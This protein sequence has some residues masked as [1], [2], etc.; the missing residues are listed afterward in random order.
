M[1]AVDRLAADILRVVA[2][3]REHIIAAALPAAPTPQYQERRW[4]LLCAVGAV[5][6]EVDPGAGAVLVAGR[7]DRFGVGEAAHIIGEN[8]GLHA[9]RTP[10]QPTHAAQD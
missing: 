6:F 3:H 4:D 5:M 7:A 1:A 2:P 9:P 8:L 10:R